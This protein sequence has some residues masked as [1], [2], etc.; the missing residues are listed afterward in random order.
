MQM[1]ESLEILKDP[2]S[3]AMNYEDERRQLILNM[4]ESWSLPKT[5]QAVKTCVSKAKHYGCIVLSVA[6]ACLAEKEEEKALALLDKLL[7]SNKG[8]RCRAQLWWEWNA[9]NIN[10]VLAAKHSQNSCSRRRWAPPIPKVFE[11]ASSCGPIWC[12]GPACLVVSGHWMGQVE[13][14][15]IWW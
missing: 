15:G 5:I 6:R 10:V 11:A 13:L 4:H 12:W 14:G 1:L 3:I 2:W 7:A 8:L 9:K